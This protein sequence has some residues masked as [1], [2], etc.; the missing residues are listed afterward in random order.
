MKRRLT[1]LVLLFFIAITNVAVSQELKNYVLIGIEYLGAF[2]DKPVFPVV[3]S[4]S[5]LG[6]EQFRRT[7][8]KRDFNYD[9]AK[10][11]IISGELVNSL[12]SYANGYAGRQPD[13]EAAASVSVYIITPKE[14]R[15]ILF[16]ERDASSLLDGFIE[17][18]RA[19]ESLFSDFSDFQKMVTSYVPKTQE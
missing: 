16:R 17:T 11:H 1:G 9:F 19:D 18:C 6:A 3:L 13:A 10:V 15:R 12:I 14:S 4:D 5:A 8:F 7:G 2:S